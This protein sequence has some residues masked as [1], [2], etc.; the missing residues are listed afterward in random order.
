MHL[1]FIGLW[2][3][4]VPCVCQVAFVCLY[5]ITVSI[6]ERLSCL[7]CVSFFSKAVD[8]W[9]DKDLGDSISSRIL[10]RSA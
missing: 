8:D 10:G 5:F 1:F 4:D 2:P 7:I 3:V 9:G 6:V